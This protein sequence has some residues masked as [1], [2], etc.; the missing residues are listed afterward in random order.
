MFDLE[1]I[2]EDSYN[3]EMSL[4]GAGA[5]AAGIGG[6]GY[7]G[8]KLKKLYDVRSKS[9]SLEKKLMKG[10]KIGKV[11]LGLSILG[12]AAASKIIPK[13]KGVASSRAFNKKNKQHAKDILDNLRKG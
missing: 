8:Y 2:A 9:K 1:K 12:A 10:A 13:V 11:G 7:G 6:A 4:L 5:G 3:D